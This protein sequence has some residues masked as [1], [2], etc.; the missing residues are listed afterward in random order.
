MTACGA[1]SVS[2]RRGLSATP[3]GAKIHVLVL[4]GDLGGLAAQNAGDRCG[5]AVALIEIDPAVCP[6]AVMR[7]R[8]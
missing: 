3:P 4:G 5:D 6:V 8:S 1:G 2:S 7:L